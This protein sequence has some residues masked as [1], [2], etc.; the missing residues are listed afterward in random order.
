MKRVYETAECE[1]IRNSI[2]WELRYEVQ[3][4]EWHHTLQ[5]IC[6]TVKA[7]GCNSTIREEMLGYHTVFFSSTKTKMRK[8]SSSF[9]RTKTR[10]KKV[11]KNKN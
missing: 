8:I 1:A 10:S 4:V 6:S 3:S 2:F 7:I 11:Q 5:N 9:M